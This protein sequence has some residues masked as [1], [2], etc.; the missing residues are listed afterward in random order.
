MNAPHF[1]PQHS[2]ARA[3][4]LARLLSGDALTAADSYR[5]SSTMRLA[6]HVHQLRHKCGWPILGSDEAVPCADGRIAYVSRYSLPRE[7]IDEARSRGADAWCDKVLEA[8][9]TLRAK[10]GSAR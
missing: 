4:V 7:A 8:R 1:P 2:S 3:E 9:E 6:A 5:G 10:A